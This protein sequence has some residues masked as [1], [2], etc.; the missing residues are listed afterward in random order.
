MSEIHLVIVSPNGESKE[1]SA[2]TKPRASNSILASHISTAFPGTLAGSWIRSSFQDFNLC[3]KVGCWHHKWWL[4]LW[5]HSANSN[6]WS[7][8]KILFYLKGVMRGTGGIKR[9]CWE[10]Q[11]EGEQEHIQLRFSTCWFNS[12]NGY[13]GQGLPK[14][15]PGAQSCVWFSGMANSGPSTWA[16]L[17]FCSRHIFR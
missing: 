2:R 11:G 13:N 10:G 7:F 9:K 4:N 5:F 14:T 8:L 16:T 15:E 6:T 12:P 1:C 3:S 17:Y